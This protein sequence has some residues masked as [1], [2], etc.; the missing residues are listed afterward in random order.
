VGAVIVALLVGES[1]AWAHSALESS[2]PGNGAAVAGAPSEV[3]LKF[4]KRVDPASPAV[5]VLGEGGASVMEGSPRVD[6]VLV[7]QP[8]RPGLAIG[9]YTVTF[10]VVSADGHPITGTLRFTVTT[11]T[12]ELAS[13]SGGA[14]AGRGATQQSSP[15]LHQGHAG[16][17]EAAPV[18]SGATGR[19][20]TAVATA[21]AGG[22]AGLT[23]AAFLLLWWL[24]RISAPD[25]GRVLYGGHRR[26]GRL[27]RAAAVLT[28]GPAALVGAGLAVA[29]AALT[30]GLGYG[31]GALRT[32]LPGL[33]EP[34]GYTP[35]LL[36]SARLAMTVAAV[37]TVG[38]LLAATVLAPVQRPVP[39]HRAPGRVPRRGLSAVAERRLTVAAYGA[40]AWC[41]AAVVAGWLSAVDSAG[42]SLSLPDVMRS[43][44]Q[45]TTGR[46]LVVVALLAA[47]VAVACR[48]LTTPAAAVA[49]LV[50]AVATVLPPVFTGHAVSGRYPHLAASGLV[51]HVV[52]AVLWAGGLLALAVSARGPAL[53]LAAAVTRFSAL[54]LA[55]F[56]AVGLSGL[57]SAWVHL[58]NVG[59]LFGS[60]YGWLVLTKLIVLVGIGAIGWWHRRSTMP[61]LR[62]G[63]RR[64]FLRLAGIEV[65]LL[66]AVF[67][68]AMALS[69]TAPP[70]PIADGHQGHVM[71]A[72]YFQ[73]GYPMPEAP[74]AGSLLSWWLPEPLFTAVGLAVAG[75]YMVG[76]RRL[77]RNGLPWPV[78][79]VAAMTTGCVVVVAA[80]S[81]GLAR[82]APVLVS[83]HAARHVVLTVVASAL[84]V[85]AAP[86]E[87][88]RRALASAGE[89][90]GESADE[91]W[92]GPREWIDAALRSRAGRMLTHPVGVGLLFASGPAVLY[93]SGLFEAT[94][95]APA[96]HL[97]VVGVGIAVGCAFFALIADAAGVR[98]RID[99]PGRIALIVAGAAGH[100]LTGV[101]LLISDRV[102]AT[103]WFT[104]LARPWASNPPVDQH[105]AGLVMVVA[106]LLVLLAVPAALRIRSAPG[107]PPAG[108]SVPVPLHRPAH[109]DDAH[110]RYTPRP[111]ATAGRR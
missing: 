26:D 92:P 39:A 7:V 18:A 86:A 36:P 2:T 104:P 70:N 110:Q 49:T 22:A 78:W 42:R 61:V 64:V 74:T 106:G 27:S 19:T 79:R 100:V 40:F 11:T 28:R 29:A 15:G 96:A 23:L 46:A 94:L 3:V 50:L 89:S 37:A 63:R 31:G 108:R 51:L 55:C 4:T 90:A 77:R 8:L 56:V 10:R 30:A 43:A 93:P 98:G 45:S 54:A 16:S 9:R 95:R 87:L 91:S 24:R 85:A 17:P 107:D 25:E 84:F 82:Y 57:L 5:A 52:P 48:T 97:A 6:G 60:T 59:A 32:R 69:R 21:A 75:L 88:A 62:N 71:P 109:H 103:D 73:L 68:T 80:A 44:A 53:Q 66:G 102:L 33:P 38:F 105:R 47:V 41:V 65:L 76:V 67:G 1:A 14:D 13:P 81:S 20:A 99:R 35:W 72:G 101:V 111:V 12:P 34:V 58:P 83:A